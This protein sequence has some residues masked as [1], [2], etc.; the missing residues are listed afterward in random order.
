MHHANLRVDKI[1]PYPELELIL[2]LKQ[3]WKLIISID[4]FQ[5]GLVGQG[6]IKSKIHML[7]LIQWPSRGGLLA[8][9]FLKSESLSGLQ[10]HCCLQLLHFVKTDFCTRV[11]GTNH[12]E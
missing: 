2:D 12:G 6:W 3:E 1:L 9:S 10:P 8:D 11:L 4:P 7:E 5:P